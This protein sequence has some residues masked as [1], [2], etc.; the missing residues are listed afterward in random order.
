MA[1][2]L[3]ELKR[4][5][6][7]GDTIQIRI[8]K[9]AKQDKYP[10]GIRYRLALIH[11]EKRVLGYDNTYPEGHHKH[12]VSFRGHEKTRYA[13]ADVETLLK[14]FRKDVNRWRADTYGAGNKK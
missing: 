10:E 11:K 8:L 2:V 9:V 4:E 5:T 14:D 7:E 6:D 3:Y 13:Y 1:E 12:S